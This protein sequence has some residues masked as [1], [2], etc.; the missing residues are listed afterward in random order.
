MIKVFLILSM[1][2]TSAHADTLDAVPK[3]EKVLIL[4]LGQKAPY[5]GVLMDGDQFRYFKTQELEAESLG[6]AY[7]KAQGET[8]WGQIVLPFLVGLSMGF[9]VDKVVK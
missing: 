1:I 8:T 9:L 6:K 4:Q 5:S 2:Q 3:P 7:A